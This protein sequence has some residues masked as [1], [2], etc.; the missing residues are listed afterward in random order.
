MPS[1]TFSV[2]QAEPHASISKKSVFCAVPLTVIAAAGACSADPDV[3]PV[4]YAVVMWF[5]RRR[6]G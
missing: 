1:V 6:A 4:F 3:T 2:K 5:A